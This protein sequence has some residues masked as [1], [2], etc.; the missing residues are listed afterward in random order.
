MAFKFEK[1]EVW[2]L[3]LEY[4]DMMYKLVKNF[5]RDEEYNLKSQLLRSVTSISLNIAEG[6]TGQTNLEFKRFINMAAR[7]NVETIACLHL[8]NRR[9]YIDE[10][11]FK[12]AYGFGEKLFAKLHALRRSIK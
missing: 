7:S 5:P 12:S 6:S 10:G 9:N 3:S 2:N 1:L 11:D 4:S 8:A